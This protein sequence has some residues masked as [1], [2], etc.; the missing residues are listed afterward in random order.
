MAEEVARPFSVLTLGAGFP[1]G[2]NTADSDTVLQ[3]DETPDGY[4][5]D[6]SKDGKLVKN[7]TAAGGTDRVQKTITLSTVPYLWHYGR[8]WNITLRTAATASNILTYG[9]MNYNDIYVP[10]KNGKVYFDEDDQ[11]IDA[12]V[13]IGEDSL[14]VVKATGTYILS[15]LNDTRALWQRTDLI[16]ELG[17]GTSATGSGR[18]LELD[19]A[20]FASNTN[21]LFAYSQGRTAEIT[22]KVRNGVTNFADKAI[23]ADYEKK[24]IIGKTLT[25]TDYIYDV[26]AGKLFRYNSTNFRYTTPRFHLPDWS[27]FYADRFYAVIEHADATDAWFVY[28]VRYEDGQW[29]DEVRVSVNYTGEMYTVVTVPLDEGMN[30]AAYTKF[31]MRI[32]NVS[33]TSGTTNLYF[34]SFDIGLFNFDREHYKR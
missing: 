17:T 15:N 30:N 31:Q 4:G 26:E 7:T 6:L 25:V 14:A 22:R 13:P 10:Q 23:T 19:G 20:L 33:S 16:Q 2:L 8:L 11:T 28:Q 32:T 27:P 9:A 18:V 24:R 3:P 5:Y 34:K 29:T 1:P 12:I 21:G